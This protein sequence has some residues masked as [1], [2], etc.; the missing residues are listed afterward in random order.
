MSGLGVSEAE[1]QVQGGRDVVVGIPPSGNQQQAVDQIGNTAKLPPPARPR[2]SRR[3]DGY[4]HTG[5]A[6]RA[7]RIVLG[8]GLH[9]SEAARR[10]SERP[11]PRHRCLLPRCRGRRVMKYALGPAAIDGAD[12]T[13]AA[14][15]DTDRAGGWQVTLEFNGTGA[16]KFAT[17]A[18]SPTRS[19]GG[20]RHL[21]GYAR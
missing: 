9:R 20:S 14:A 1:V 17:T 16:A 13:D 10:P 5:S 6:G 18:N 21:G 12:I 19:R 4:R 15:L 11:C 7:H 8:A 3:S 2:P